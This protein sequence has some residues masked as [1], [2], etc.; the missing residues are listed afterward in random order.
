MGMA[1]LPTILSEI[2]MHGWDDGE[3]TPEEKAARF[4][5]SLERY[6]AGMTVLRDVAAFAQNKIT[7]GYNPGFKLSPIESQIE[8][9]AKAADVV[10]KITSG[11]DLSMGDER[12]LIM[13]MGFLTGT[14]GK[15]VADTITGT[16]A[17]L[18][19]DAPPT[20]ILTGAP[21]KK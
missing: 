3:E 11:D 9:V 12:S 8:S 14:P 13:G 1:V 17:W 7:G 4:A 18:N 21:R 5:W 6:F 15:I 16:Q 19:D 20:A 2:L 10:A